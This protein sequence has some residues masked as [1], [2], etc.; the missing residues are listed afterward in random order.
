MATSGSVDYSLDARAAITAAIELVGSVA[1]GLTP[2][3]STT[4]LAKKHA[5]LLLKTWGAEERLWIRATASLALVAST[6]SYSLP[7]A[8]RVLSARRRTSNVDT[9]IW[10]MSRDDY[11]SYPTKTATGYPFQAFFDPQRATRT[12]YVINVPDATIAASTMLQY[13]Y[14]RVIE[15]I[16]DLANDIDIPQEWLEAFVYSLAARLLIPLAKWVSNP[17]GAAKIEERATALYAELS[18]QDDED[19]SVFFQPA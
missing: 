8:R 5:N 3:A 12:L 16:D 11:D 13:T 6:A 10:M 9:P 4:D 15:D 17:N 2:D 7:L 18:S 1:I 19:A 14:L